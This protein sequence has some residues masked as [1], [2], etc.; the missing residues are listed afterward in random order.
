MLAERY[1]EVCVLFEQAPPGSPSEWRQYGL[2]LLRSHEFERAFEPLKTAHAQG[3]L[4]GGVEFANLLRLEGRFAEAI[5]LLERLSP[6]LS[7]EL[8]LRAL[9]W[10]GTAEFQVGRVEQGLARTVRARYGY[11]SLY[12]EVLT[13][14][15]TQT[16]AQMY[17]IDRRPEKARSLYR[18]SLRMMPQ[19]SYPFVRIAALLG[20][21]ELL[22]LKFE[23]SEAQELVDEVFSLL[24]TL[25]VP[26]ARY[27]ASALLVQASV[28]RHQ[29]RTADLSVVVETLRVLSADITEFE[30]LTGIAE[31]VADVLSVQGAHGRAAEALAELRPQ[32]SLTEKLR[33]LEGVLAWRAGRLGDAQDLLV[34]VLDG[35]FASDAV[36]RGEAVVA[37]TLSERL[38]F[39]LYLSA[40]QLDA[41]L[42]GGVRAE[43]GGLLAELSESPEMVSF[44]FLLDEA[45]LLT[46]FAHLDADLCPAVELVTLR[47]AQ[48]MG[49]VAHVDDTLM[50]L[51]IHSFG[52]SE[53]LRNGEYML[54]SLPGSLVMLVYLALHPGRSRQEVQG[55]LYPELH[56]DVADA[57]F[58]EVFREVRQ[59][60]GPHALRN[61][62][63]LQV[64][65]YALGAGV[66]LDLDVTEFRVA[67][68]KRNLAAALALYHGPFLP[69]LDDSTWVVDARLELQLELAREL[70]LHLREAR[71]GGDDR[72]ALL[73]CGQFLR[74]APV[75][76]HAEVEAW[77]S[78]AL[79]R[80]EAQ[81]GSGGSGTA[82]GVARVL[83]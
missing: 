64:P 55:A 34:E 45:F 20:L 75:D 15:I 82:E 25:E 35:R 26:P 42:T 31:L 52:R 2:A 63:T 38:R 68:H 53:L 17:A 76:Q 6:L 8:R 33:A 4:E 21:A 36:E 23:L 49:E 83:N 7:G 70:G 46:E 78:E 1:P 58:R 77:R 73:L 81:E 37:L 28:Y 27:R 79:P 40:V 18:E 13:G 19:G 66:R 71:A 62:G 3:D 67:L 72:R 14:Q 51:Q 44:R 56:P 57:Y 43:L 69:G 24:V 80:V 47:L 10:W 59:L 41:G 74:V 5:A 61:S 60:L 54:F 29:K 22:V 65:V 32:T 16:L 48:L 12:D 11:M 50:H 9:R 39:R 30:T